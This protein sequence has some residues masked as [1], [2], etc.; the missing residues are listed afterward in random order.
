MKEGE[1]F[2]KK[3]F[4]LAVFIF[5]LLI[6]SLALYFIF[7][8]KPSCQDGILNQNEERT[9]C[10]GPCLPCSERLEVRDLE[11]VS[12]EW[13]VDLAKKIDILGKITNPNLLV[14]LEKFDFRFV[15]RDEVGE[16]IFSTDWQT[17]F[18]LPKETKGVLADRKS[19]V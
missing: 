5:G 1:R 13:S 6:V 2:F 7:K 10:G 19:V 11:T 12:V 9:D 17:G 15:L 8:E 14:G 4:I 16:E 18:I 3:F